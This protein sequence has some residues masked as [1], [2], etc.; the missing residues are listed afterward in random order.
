MGDLVF[1]DKDRVDTVMLMGGGQWG[2]LSVNSLSSCH[3]GRQSL[4]TFRPDGHR[5]TMWDRTRH[6][7]S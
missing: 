4:P 5:V 6:K 7:C 2:W 1:G 3:C